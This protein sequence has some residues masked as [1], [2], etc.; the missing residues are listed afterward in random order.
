M[1]LENS[2]AALFAGSA[3]EFV[4]MAPASS[5]TA[6]LVREYT[7]VW[8]RCNDSEVRSWKNSLTALARVV[9]GSTLSGAGVGVELKLPGN[10]CR[11]DASFVARN[12]EGHPHV[13][14][15]ELKQWSAVGPSQYPDNVVVNG[16]QK[17]HPSVQ[18]ADYA[19]HLWGTHSAFTEGGFGLSACSYLHN[20]PAGE[21]VAITGLQYEGAL[22][23]APLFTSGNEGGLQRLMQQKVSGGDGLKLLPQLTEGRYRPSKGL[24]ENIGRALRR[25]PVWRLL[26]E[27][28]LAFNLVRGMVERASRTGQKAALL[29]V[30]GPG[31]GKSVIAVHLVVELGKG[32]RYSVA[33]ATGSKAFTTNLLAIA[34]RGGRGV[35]RYFNSFT[36]KRTPENVVDVLLCDEAHRIRVSSNSFRTPKALQS[37][38]P[39][40]QELLRAARVSVFFI[41]NQQNVRPDEIGS[42]EEIEHGAAAAGI[43]LQRVNLTGQFRCNGCAPYIDW[44]ENTLSDA[45]VKPGGWLNREYEFR[46]LDCPE[47]LEQ[48]ALERAARGSSARLVAGFCWPWSAPRKDGTL[49]RDVRIG[50]WERPWNE[51]APVA[52]PA[53]S[54]HPYYLWATQPER[55]REV[56]CIYS[57]QGFEFDYC[58]VIIGDDYVWRPGHGWVASKAASCDS[59][60]TQTK[61]L[62][63]AAIKNLLRQTYR[64]LLTRGMKGTF[65]YSTDYETRQFL[66]ALV[67]S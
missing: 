51:K 3:A 4:E 50:P 28:R 24:I 40:I 55:I 23:D 30:G 43:E 9:T 22:S 37:E 59:K 60:I 6:H 1:P 46:V 35:F 42:I 34:P 44:V 17:V 7:R 38:I 11:I 13:L 65:V 10:D 25:E 16:H 33:H 53:P 62:S 20:L 48:L 49:V 21:E 31:T 54:R 5:L 61:D 64:V 47:A 12:E 45:P 32:G 36:H 18:V 39:Q 57:A 14:L 63:T 58:G 8:G 29:V 67:A 41:D 2:G 26:D 66:Q 19:A 56:G 52:E 27:Q 15:V